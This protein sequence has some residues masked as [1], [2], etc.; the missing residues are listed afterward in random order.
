MNAE[1]AHRHRGVMINRPFSRQLF[2]CWG[3]WGQGRLWVVTH[4]SLFWTVGQ[5]GIRDI[6]SDPQHVCE[7]EKSAS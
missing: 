1:A 7:P 4:L 2:V 6:L 5:Y 3:L